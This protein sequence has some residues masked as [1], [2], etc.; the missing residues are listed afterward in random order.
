MRE[1]GREEGE[2]CICVGVPSHVHAEGAPY[3][4]HTR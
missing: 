1:E 4:C 2:L 3:P